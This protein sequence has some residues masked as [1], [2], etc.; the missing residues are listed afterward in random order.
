MGFVINEKNEGALVVRRSLVRCEMPREARHDRPGR[1]SRE[2]MNTQRQTLNVQCS[3]SQAKAC[4]HRRHDV[5]GLTLCRSEGIEC[6]P[7]T[8]RI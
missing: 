1:G 7:D 2:Q 6:Q 4:G 5:D 8:H 3:I